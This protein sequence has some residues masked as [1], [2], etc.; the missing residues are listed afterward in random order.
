MSEGEWGGR[1]GG[2]N[3]EGREGKVYPDLGGGG[4]KV[5]PVGS[6]TNGVMTGKVCKCYTHTERA[7]VLI[8]F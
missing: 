1:N 7:H 5:N 3:I 4:G 8:L 2:E 6:P